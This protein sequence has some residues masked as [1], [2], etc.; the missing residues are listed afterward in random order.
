[1][2]GDG[3]QVYSCD[4]GGGGYAWVFRAPEAALFDRAGRQ[5]GSHGAGP[6]WTLA[7]GSSVLGEKVAEAAAPA[8][9]AIAWLLLR[10][11]SHE[12]TGRLADAAWVRRASTAGGTAPDGGCDA[13]HAGETARIRYS[14]VYEFWR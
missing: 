9:H 12:G 7:D 2:V 11:K 13:A 5:V 6:R 10:V 8:P 1:V 14:A 4:A 3:V